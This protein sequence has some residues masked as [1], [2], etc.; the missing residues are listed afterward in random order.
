[1]PTVWKSASITPVRKGDKRELVENYK[2]QRETPLPDGRRMVVLARTCRVWS[3]SS[4]HYHRRTGTARFDGP[5]LP[6]V[7]TMDAQLRVYREHLGLLHP[8]QVLYMDMV[9][10]I[11]KWSPG[12][13]KLPTG[14]FLGKLK[15]EL[16]DEDAIVEFATAGPKTYG[17]CTHLGTLECKVHGFRLNIRGQQ[18][19]NFNLLKQNVLEEG[20]QPQDQPVNSLLVNLS[21]RLL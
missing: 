14:P 18:Q 13:P 11:Y 9:S 21:S 15:K 4:S 1:M 7:E 10:L 2:C 17:F 8:E 16:D 6:A 12:L 5:R 19:L 20:Q 3:L